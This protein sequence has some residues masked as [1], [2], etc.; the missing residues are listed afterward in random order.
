MC[1]ARWLVG[2]R[3]TTPQ[4]T[5]S[6][7]EP[8]SPS[9]TWVA[10]TAAVCRC[11]TRW[12]ASCSPSRTR[13]ARASPPTA[14]APTRTRTRSTRGTWTRSPSTTRS[15]SCSSPRAT[16]ERTARA[17]SALPRRRRTHSP[18]ARR[19]RLRRVSSAWGALA[20]RPA[21]AL[22]PWP[23]SPPSAPPLMVASSPTWWHRGTL[24]SPLDRRPTR[25]GSTAG[26]PHCQGRPWPPLQRPEMPPWCG[27]TCVRGTTPPA[28]PRRTTGSRPWAL[29]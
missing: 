22:T 12:T 15:S 23:P 25:R 5:A 21:S 14:G 4:K 17:L 3:A 10:P 29:W 1:L 19:S 9:S 11:P 16:R 6:P 27:S 28:L 20:L 7:M 26:W 8:S 24:S 2:P 13:L 18:W